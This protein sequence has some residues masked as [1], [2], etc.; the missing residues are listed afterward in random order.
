VNAKVMK[1]PRLQK[2]MVQPMPFDMKRMAYGG[3]KVF[4]DV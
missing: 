2:M 4:V 3:F 1:D